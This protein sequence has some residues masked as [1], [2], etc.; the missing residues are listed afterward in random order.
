MA[1]NGTRALTALAATLAAGACGDSA[2]T[3][4]GQGGA[5]AT[6]AAT[7]ST[8]G[9]GSTTSGAG[10]GGSAFEAFTATFES[11]T[12]HC[13]LVQDTTLEDPAENQLQTRFNLTGTDLGIPAV[14]GDTLYL[15]FG[16]TVGYREIW[17][18]GEDPDSVA[19]VPLSAVVTDPTEVC[20][21]LEFAV[22]AD[23]PSVAND[24]NPGILRDFAGAFLTP[25][26]GE[27]I[28]A[29]VAQPAGPFPNMPGTFEVPG[30][31]LAAGGKIYV[32]Y[33]GMAELAPTVRMTKSYLAAWDD[34]LG[35]AP[36]YRILRTIDE[37]DP[38]GPLAG[39]FIQ[40]APALH[41]GF[42]Y[43]FG[44]GEYRRSGVHL[45]RVPVTGLED[46][47]G[48]EVFDPSSASFVAP[49]TEV[50]PIF[51]SEGVGE[52]SVAYV[53]AANAWV[54]LY[55]RELHDGGGIITDNR[56]VL[57]VAAKPEGPWTDVVTV[58][59]MADPAFQAAHCCG[60][61]CP[62]DQILHCDRAGLYGAY[63]LPAVTVTPGAAPGSATLEVPF[64]A[65]TWDPY[66]V[67]L[68]STR[69]AIAPAG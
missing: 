42:V 46:G 31:A 16:D 47:A 60:A 13:E 38:S 67:V 56:I 32:F 33:A 24:T 51:E 41:D 57:R 65:S 22:T 8:G 39:R 50:A 15:F 43:L 7:S 52:I 62:G 36:G 48:T 55:Q 5:A 61:T 64:L 58:V 25:P 2:G 30:G 21:S 49:G 66:G 63:L 11:R 12:F 69:V 68:F 45:A 17:P 19:R 44:T 26:A 35:F 14:L 9:P 20:R 37:L 27:P 40:I 34:P 4:D 18:F 59:D 29:Y 6:T 28:E 23:I 54:A 10:T 1:R 53:E 3:S